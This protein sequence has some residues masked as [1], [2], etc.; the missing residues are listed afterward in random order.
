[1]FDLNNHNPDCAAIVLFSFIVYSSPDISTPTLNISA[2]L[3]VEEAEANFGAVNHPSV[4][5]HVDAALLPAAGRVVGERRIPLYVVYCLQIFRGHFLQPVT[6]L[7]KL[8]HDLNEPVRPA[9]VIR[10]RCQ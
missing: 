6:L 1:M 4:I 2:H 5:L 9:T 7:V 8:R 3:A 10:Q